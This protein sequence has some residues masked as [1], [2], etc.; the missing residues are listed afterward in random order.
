MSGFH[1]SGNC[2]LPKRGDSYADTISTGLSVSGR[3]KNSSA[4]PV[5]ATRI[6]THVLKRGGHGVLSPADRL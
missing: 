6:H 2:D 3:R 1:V 5:R 4:T